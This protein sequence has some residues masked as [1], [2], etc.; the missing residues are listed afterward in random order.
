[1]GRD[2]AAILFALISSER[3]LFSGEMRAVMLPAHG[4]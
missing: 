1:M 3:V 4:G 2:V